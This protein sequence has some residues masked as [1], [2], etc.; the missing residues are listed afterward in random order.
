MGE[1]M[2]MNK[3]KNKPYFTVHLVAPHKH[4]NWC[5]AMDGKVIHHI[6]HFK[7]FAKDIG[8]PDPSSIVLNNEVDFYKIK[9]F[10]EQDDAASEICTQYKIAQYLFNNCEKFKNDYSDYLARVTNACKSQFD[11]SSK[12]CAACFMPN[13]L[14]L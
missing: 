12:M 5:I 4:F 1:V 8:Y 7:S 11:K 3:S 14:G 6:A 9:A 13:E 2:V 10:T